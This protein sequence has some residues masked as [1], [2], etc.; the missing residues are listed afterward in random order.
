[1]SDIRYTILSE[2]I[3]YFDRLENKYL[4]AEKLKER[5]ANGQSV[6]RRTSVGR[7]VDNL[8]DGKVLLRA[9]ELTSSNGY[10]PYDFADENSQTMIHN[11]KLVKIE[12]VT[13]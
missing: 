10:A 7:I 5:I 4:T 8:E 6:T 11:K 13:V 9:A 1:M 2:T 3:E 12:E